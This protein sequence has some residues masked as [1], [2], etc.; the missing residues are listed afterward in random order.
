MARL[1][2]IA[3]VGRQ[4][5]GTDEH[6]IDTRHVGDRF[7]V[8]QRLAGFD[9]HQHADLLGRPCVVVLDPAEA[10]R[11]RGRRE[12]PDALRRVARRSDR[13]T[14]LLLVLHVRDQKG[15]RSGVQVALD[16]H[17]IVPRHPYDGVRRPAHRRLQLAVDHRQIVRGVLGVDQ[18]PVK[19]GPGQDLD[20]DVAR[21]ARPE[22]DLLASLFDRP[23]ERVDG[24]VHGASL[25]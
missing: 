3:H 19:P 18:Q 13:P 20:R 24:H 5:T 2:Q 15:L 16:R 21:Q 9:L 12:A 11:P 1:S 22:A 17:H 25:P 8:T 14:R 6:A 10:R 4:V 7:Q 23:L